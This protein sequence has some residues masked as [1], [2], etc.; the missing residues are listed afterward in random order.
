MQSYSE[1]SETPE[2]YDTSSRQDIPEFHGTSE[3]HPY[4]DYRDTSDTSSRQDAS[5]HQDTSDVSGSLSHTGYPIITR[6]ITSP[7]KQ[8]PL[9]FLDRNS[10]SRIDHPGHREDSGGKQHAEYPGT[11]EK[12]NRPN[13]P[14]YPSYQPRPSYNGSLRY[15]SIYPTIP[16]TSGRPGLYGKPSMYYYCLR[17]EIYFRTKKNSF[18]IHTSIV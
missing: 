4:T 18:E 1:Y 16:R 11:P 15:P 5:V 2:T 6:P 9:E 7:D 12:S 10:S 8:R 17:L 14:R 13:I 3:T